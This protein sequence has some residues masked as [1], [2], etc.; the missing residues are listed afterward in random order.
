[1]DNFRTIAKLTLSAG[2]L[3]LAMAA[4]GQTASADEPITIGA[5]IAL[6]GFVQPYDQDPSR[7]AE[8]AIEELNA[9]G[10]LLGRQLKMIKADTKSD[11]AQGAVAGMEVL[12]EGA[13]IVIV[14]G[15]YD[16][17]GGA[18]RAANARGKIAIAPFAADPKF[19]VQGIGPY[20]FTFSTASLTVGTVLAEFAWD[21]GWKTA[22]TLTQNTIQYDQSVT[23]SF[24]KRFAELGG[25]LVGEDSFAIDD[26]SIAAQITRIKSLPKAPDA[27]LLSTFTPAGPTALR[28]IRAA[29]L[30]M[31]VLSGEDM[32]GDYWLE[33]V[34]DLSDFYVAAMASLY[35]DDPRPDV[36]A[37]MDEFKKRHGG[38]PATAHTITGY[39]AIMGVARA[40]EAAGSVDGDAVKAE[41]EKFKDVDLLAGPTSFTPEL[42]INLDRP[43]VIVKVQD[44]KPAFLE[45]RDPKKV[46]EVTF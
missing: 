12:D 36:Q 13:D 26:A 17:G 9:K 7:A 29:G 10:G 38:H 15:D 25:E 5:A 2:A 41:L 1:M 28:Q 45:L 30:E 32:D 35:G 34:P 14:T 16:F 43:L 6:S 39:D 40:I 3:A 46:P 22:Y 19:G 44:G 33:S 21:Q 24:R 11:F 37:L 23:A 31:P 8:I 20:A 18:A 4:G 27:L 42:H